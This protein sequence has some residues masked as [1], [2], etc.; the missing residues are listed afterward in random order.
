MGHRSA[1]EGSFLTPAV[2]PPSA[3]AAVSALQEGHGSTAE[4]VREIER[5]TSALETL[6]EG[7]MALDASRRVLFANHNA[8]L[9]FGLQPAPISGQ[10]LD[11]LIRHPSLNDAVSATFEEPEPF[12]AEFEVL[13]PRRVIAFK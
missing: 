12:S 1:P 3:D 9:F 13:E 6:P 4:L 5:L 11:E 8:F 2:R 10:T 7:V